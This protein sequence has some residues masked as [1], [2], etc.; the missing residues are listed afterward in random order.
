MARGEGL[1]ESLGATA[2]ELRAY[3]QA[4]LTCAT[5]ELQDAAAAVVFAR[6]A[7]EF[8][9]GP[10]AEILDTLARALTRGRTVN[11]K[12]TASPRD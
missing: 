10:D 7:V 6:R 4:L 11:Q 12:C 5:P 2:D 3:A 1:Y 9:G 8:A